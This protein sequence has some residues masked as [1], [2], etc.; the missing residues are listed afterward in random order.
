MLF[1]SDRRYQ[2]CY[3]QG[4]QS[5]QERL[6]PVL[7]VLLECAIN[8]R[9]LRKYL[10]WRVLPPLRDVHTRPEQG[11]TLRNKL[12][13]LLTSPVTSVRDLAA[14]LL[15]VLCKESGKLPNRI[16]LLHRYTLA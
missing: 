1:K 9:L 16:F 13:R 11:S 6:S 2:V 15:F 10:R 5:L 8:H 12:C 14:E 7:T 4:V 3:R